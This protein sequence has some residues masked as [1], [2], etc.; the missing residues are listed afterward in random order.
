MQIMRLSSKCMIVVGEGGPE[1]RE[2]YRWRVGARLSLREAAKMLGLTPRLL[3][4][5]EWGRAELPGDT[6][7]AMEQLYQKPREVDP[8]GVK[9][10]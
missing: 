6:A 3:S 1:A 4:D 10:L 7:Q 2:C 5:F 9:A 8:S